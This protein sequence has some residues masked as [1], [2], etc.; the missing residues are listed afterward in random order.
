[1]P[2]TTY[3]LPN[4]YGFATKELDQDATLAYNNNILRRV[5]NSV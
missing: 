3:R 1:M 5:R 2:D 4:L